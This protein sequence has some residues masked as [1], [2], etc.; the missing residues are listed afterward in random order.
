[1][2]QPDNN[3][4]LGSIARVIGGPLAVTTPP[5]PTTTLPTITIVAKATKLAENGPKDKVIVTRTGDVSSDLTI[6]YSAKGSAQAGVNYK[7]LT[8]SVVIPAGSASAAIKLKPVNDGVAD[9]TFV[10]KLTI[11]PDASYTVGA[12]GKA[13]IKILNVD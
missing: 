3:A 9:G 13:K 2:I 5:P 8:G 7:R 6:S 12:P 1:M 11:L 10:L 4:I